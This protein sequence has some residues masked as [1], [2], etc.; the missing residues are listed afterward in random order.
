MKLVFLITSVLKGPQCLGG[1]KQASNGA[2]REPFLSAS[3]PGSRQQTV[4]GKR[5]LLAI[6]REDPRTWQGVSGGK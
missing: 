3:T 6:I 1:D 5:P 4:L 2:R